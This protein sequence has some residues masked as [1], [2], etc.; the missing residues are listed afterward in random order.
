MVEP[1]SLPFT[2]TTVN[3]QIPQTELAT[4]RK[5]MEKLEEMLMLHFRA[6]INQQADADV[7]PILDT[8]VKTTDT[9]ECSNVLHQS[10]I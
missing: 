3:N 5:V 4:S 7:V 8:G 10:K 6:Y 1:D 2:P 9:V